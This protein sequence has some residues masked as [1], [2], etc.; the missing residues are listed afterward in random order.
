MLF[1][2][3]KTLTSA[4]THLNHE[5][6]ITP[7]EETNVNTVDMAGQSFQDLQGELQNLVG[8]INIIYGWFQRVF[9]KKL[10]DTCEHMNLFSLWE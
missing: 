5:L 7:D 4:T 2:E 1:Q 9:L 6:K 10:P 3:A 8:I